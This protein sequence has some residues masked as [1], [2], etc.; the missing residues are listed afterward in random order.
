MLHMREKAC[1]PPHGRPAIRCVHTT[2]DEYYTVTLGLVLLGFL[3]SDQASFYD[4]SI[5]VQKAGQLSG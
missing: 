1:K 2:K 5:V 4:G 3:Q